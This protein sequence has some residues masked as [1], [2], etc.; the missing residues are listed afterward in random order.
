MKVKVIGAGPMQNKWVND[1]LGNRFQPGTEAEIDDDAAE[2]LI[3]LG[4]VEAV[5]GRKRKASKDDE[6]TA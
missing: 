1:G 4:Q 3:K 2:I 6:E 5:S